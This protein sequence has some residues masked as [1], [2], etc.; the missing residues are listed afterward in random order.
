MRNRWTSFDLIDE[1]EQV[2]P[3]AFIKKDSSGQVGS[4]GGYRGVQ[5]A[6]KGA[7]RVDGEVPDT[8]ETAVTG[9]ILPCQVPVKPP[10]AEM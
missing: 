6:F 3:L 4:T 1:R 9:P 5:Y 7:I 8:S 2:A 10:F